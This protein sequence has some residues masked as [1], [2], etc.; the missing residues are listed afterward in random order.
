[1][2]MASRHRL[3]LFGLL[4]G[5]VVLSTVMSRSSAPEHSAEEMAHGHLSSNG[6]LGTFSRLPP[7]APTLRV[8]GSWTHL[9]A[10]DFH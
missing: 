10:C 9:C 5:T 2:D 3:A 4:V 7:N 8:L 1:M 6:D